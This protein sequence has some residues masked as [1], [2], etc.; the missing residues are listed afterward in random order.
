MKQ[1]LTTDGATGR[2]AA[3]SLQVH[4]RGSPVEVPRQAPGGSSC[5]YGLCSLRWPLAARLPCGRPR[6]HPAKRL[7]EGG[8]DRLLT[9]AA[10]GPG[11]ERQRPVQAG[12]PA[13]G[14][15]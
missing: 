4:L 11:A 15:P 13:P 7:A 5:W 10:P 9:G 3:R 12:P 1:R 14:A 2:V 6:R 8:Q